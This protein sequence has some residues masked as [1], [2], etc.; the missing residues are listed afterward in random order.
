MSKNSLNIGN[1]KSIFQSGGTADTVVSPALVTVPSPH[2]YMSVSW[3]GLD[4]QLCWACIHMVFGHS[5][6]FSGEIFIQITWIICSQY[7]LYGDLIQV[8][9]Y[10]RQMFCQWDTCQLY[11]PILLFWDRSYVVSPRA[12]YVVLKMIFN[13]WLTC[14]HLSSVRIASLNRTPSFMQCWELT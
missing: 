13:F 7:S 3:C 12:C 8:L 5:Y 11:L 4:D 9:E 2:W 10:A 14:Y 1:S 6:I